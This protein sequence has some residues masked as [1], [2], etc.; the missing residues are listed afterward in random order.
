[1]NGRKWAN[2][3]KIIKKSLSYDGRALLFVGL[4]Q[5]STSYGEAALSSTTLHILRRNT[6]SCTDSLA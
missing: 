6:E 5:L 1:M 3:L 2:P 4:T